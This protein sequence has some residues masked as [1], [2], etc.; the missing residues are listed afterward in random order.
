MCL[1]FFVFFFTRTDIHTYANTIKKYV[2][3]RMMRA[4]NNETIVYKKKGGENCTI[5]PK[6]PVL[7]M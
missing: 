2:V 4:A 5:A 6:K 3:V 7:E 1:L